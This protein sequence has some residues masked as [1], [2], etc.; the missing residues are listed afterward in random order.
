MTLVLDTALLT[1]LRHRHRG[2]SS[3]YVVAYVVG[4]LR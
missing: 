4:R 2:K 1:L 3:D